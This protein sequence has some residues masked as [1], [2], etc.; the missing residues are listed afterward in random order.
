MMLSRRRLLRRLGVSAAAAPLVP[1]LDRTAD[2]AVLPKRLLLVY[3]PNGAHPPFWW[4]TGT[5][6]A[7]TF[8]PGS[9]LEPLDPFRSFLNFP[10]N[11]KR[12][13]KDRGG[14]HEKG[15]GCLWTGA[16]LNPGNQANG[17]GYPS[18]A[19]IDQIIG[20]ALPQE[21]DFR[22]L[23]VAV[24]PD[25][26]GADGDTLKHMC[27][28][29]SNQPM[30]AVSS[31]YVLFDRLTGNGGSLGAPPGAESAAQLKVQRQSVIDLVRRELN[32]LKP[33]IDKDDRYKLDRHLDSIRAVETRL[34]ATAAPLAPGCLVK[35]TGQLDLNANDNF[36]PLLKL[37]SDLIVSALACDRTRIA[38]LQWSHGFSLVVHRW[39]NSPDNH[40]SITHDQSP[41]GVQNN[42]KVNRWYATQ[43]AYLLGELRKI[44]E[45][46]GTL[47]DNT[48]VVWASELSPNAGGDVH[49]PNPVC[50]VT[51]GGLG[52]R[53]RTGRFSDFSQ[54][55]DWNQMLVTICQAMGANINV[56]GDLGGVGPVP[57]LLA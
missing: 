16:S 44:P 22:T 35:P 12:V 24:Q 42:V 30:P 23:E 17:G 3:S 4:P 8:K 1:L 45:G 51:A 7:F 13:F 28:A 40:H 18:A 25:T 37:Q 46:N 43:L 19:S 57:G 26:P 39:V 38:T 6:T 27:Y 52:G 34:Q 20:K 33:K 55:Y 32:T 54:K 2:A 36:P 15:I 14:G 11:L 56:V 49:E 10:M 5:E 9:I 50:V 29:G 31:P 48:L 47:L 21:T 53:V 41:G